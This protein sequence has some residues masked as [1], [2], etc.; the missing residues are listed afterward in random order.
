[1]SLYLECLRMFCIAYVDGTAAEVDV[2]VEVKVEV[3]RRSSPPLL[4]PT[5]PKT[6]GDYWR[7]QVAGTACNVM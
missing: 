3:V 6:F 7:N 5:K 1:M 2:Q 4:Y